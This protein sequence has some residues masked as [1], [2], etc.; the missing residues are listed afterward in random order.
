MAE[1]PAT[2]EDDLGK[3]FDGE[4]VD[5][6]VDTPVGGDIPDS[7]GVEEA[8]EAKSDERPRDEHGRFIKSDGAVNEAA[9]KTAD[10]GENAAP[11]DK[12]AVDEV[13]GADKAGEEKAQDIAQADLPPSTYTTAAKAAYLALPKDSPLRADIKKRE[14]DFQKGISQYKQAAEAGTRLMNEI[15]PYMGIIQSEGGTPERA[16]K[17]LLQ[18]AYQ[19]RTGTPQQKGQLVMQIAQQ[20]G[21]DLSQFIRQPQ[22]GQ[23]GQPAQFD[24]QSLTPVVSQ[25]LSPLEQKINQIEGR[26]MTAQQQ[27]EQAEQQEA[28]GRIEAFRSAADAK[29]QPLHPYFDDVRD[30]MAGLL[31]SGNAQDLNQAYEMAC[32]AHPEVSKALTA[33]QQ[34]AQEAQRLENAK[35]RAAEASRAKV[36]NASGQGGVGIASPRSNSLEDDL[37]ALYD[38]QVGARV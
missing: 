29:G 12:P 10:N 5:T 16:V 34:Q 22:T 37:G 32:R 24:P 31:G 1:A 27:R 35:R 3:A 13:A 21:A 14:A 9:G 15:Q 28:L 36:V 6:N 26:F 2:L 17:S 25:L 38:S 11:A 8:A 33:A 4:S 19:L 23:D 18:T 7:G 30:M 20:Y